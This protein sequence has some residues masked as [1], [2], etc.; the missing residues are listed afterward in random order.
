MP[1]MN[2]YNEKELLEQ[3][4]K[5]EETAIEGIYR[6]FWQPL[7]ISG[8]NVLRDKAACEDIIQDIFLQ[9]WVKRE[10]LHIKES[11]GAYLHSAVRYQVLRHI[12]NNPAESRFFEKLEERTAG[13][14]PEHAMNLKEINHLVNKVVKGLPERCRTVYLLSREQQLSHKEIAQQMHISTKTVENHL[15][16]ALKVL[17]SSLNKLATIF[18]FL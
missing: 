16:N 11:L 17:R 14:S 10:S 9:L 8:Y 12:R 5:G 4:S 1:D 13:P 7:F 2:V 6:V 18:L 3:L 15:T